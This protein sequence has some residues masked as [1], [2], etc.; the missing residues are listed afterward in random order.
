MKWFSIDFKNDSFGIC[1]QARSEEDAKR[2]VENPLNWKD[3]KPRII[4]SIKE[5]RF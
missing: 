2:I 5:E 4:D 3:R 1:I